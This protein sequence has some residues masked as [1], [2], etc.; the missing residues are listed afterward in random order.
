MTV[1]VFLCVCVCVCVCVCLGATVVFNTFNLSF[2]QNC[3]PKEHQK[4]MSPLFSLPPSSSVGRWTMLIPRSGGAEWQMTEGLI[5]QERKRGIT[6]ERVTAAGNG[7]QQQRSGTSIRR[8]GEVSEQICWYWNDCVS[9]HSLF[10]FLCCCSY[11]FLSF[12]LS[13]CKTHIFMWHQH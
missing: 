13:L 10:F 4:S 9:S 2:D 7:K 12:F 1:C 8:R 5:Q 6:S 3:F 11:I